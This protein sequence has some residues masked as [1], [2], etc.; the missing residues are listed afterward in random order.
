M[1]K[2]A[3]LLIVSTMVVCRLYAQTN[4]FPPSGNVGIG[5]TS[6]AVPLHLK[7]VG[8]SPAWLGLDKNSGMET[9]IQFLKSGSVLF[10]MYSDNDDADALKIQS[11]ALPGENDAYPRLFIPYNNKDLYVGLSGGNVAIGHK[12]PYSSSR[13]HVK[14]LVNT[15]WSVI[16]EAALNDRIIGMSHDGTSGLISTSYLGNSGYS[17]LTFQ[18]SNAPRLTLSTDGKVGV[19]TVNP[20]SKLHLEQA[21]GAWSDGIRLSLAGRNWDIVSDR[22]GDRLIIAK[23]QS[24]SQGLVIENGNVGIGSSSPTEKLT[25]NGTIY[26]K[27]VK[28]DLNVPAPDYVFKKDYDLASLEEVKAHIDQYGHLPEVPSAMEM[29]EG[30]NLGEMNM[31]LLKKVE[32]LTLYVIQQKELLENQKQEIQLLKGLLK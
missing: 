30:I 16:S 13:L 4:T 9:G 2:R 27:E 3:L 26:G 1:M 25:V 19:G 17:P 12:T 7:P 10:Y 28:V 15:P 24:I 31:I 8:S 18:T 6:P 23:D 21:S 32:E 5:T 22:Y 20:A 11:T 14:A 29:E